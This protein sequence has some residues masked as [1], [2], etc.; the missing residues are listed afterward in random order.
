MGGVAQTAVQ[1]G[2]ALGQGMG[3]AIQNNQDGNFL[4]NAMGAITDVAKTTV[5]AGTQAVSG[6]VDAGKTTVSGVVD[7]GKDTMGAVASNIPGQ[8]G[9]NMLQ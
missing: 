1:T 6:V 2:S 5:S 8:L 4:Q 3:N 7:A 9:G